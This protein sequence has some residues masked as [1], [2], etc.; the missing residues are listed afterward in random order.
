MLGGKVEG[1]KERGYTAGREKLGRGSLSRKGAGPM[2]VKGRTG[3]PFEQCFQEAAKERRWVEKMTEGAV[4]RKG[5]NQSPE[6]YNK[7]ERRRS[8]AHKVWRRQTSSKEEITGPPNTK[9]SGQ[10]RAG[11]ELIEGRIGVVLFRLWYKRN[12]P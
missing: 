7:G 3:R 10:Y 8:T 4:V 12:K 6:G 9:P 1:G 5:S 11:S 2:L